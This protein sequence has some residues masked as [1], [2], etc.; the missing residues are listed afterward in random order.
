MC[1]TISLNLNDRAF[2]LRTLDLDYSF[3]REFII[4]PR[5]Y[6]TENR[7]L[8]RNISKHGFWGIGD[9]VDGFPLYA[10][11]VNEMGLTIGGL[12]F[13]TMNGYAR[14]NVSGGLAPFEIIPYVLGNFDNAREACN[15]LSHISVV[16]IQFN[17]RIKNTPLHFHIADKN[18]CFVL[19]I[20][21][22]RVE[23]KENPFGVLT[24]SPPFSFHEYNMKRY[25]NIS[26]DAPQ[27]KNN[28]DLYSNGLLA[29]GLPGDFS[30]PSRFV[31][32]AWLRA[33]ARS[34][35][36]KELF[37]AISL[38]ENLSIPTGAVNTR[39]GKM[40]HTRYY[41]L[42]DLEKMC[43]VIRKY[44]SLSPRVFEIKKESLTKDSLIS[45]II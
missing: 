21:D 22:R 45:Y 26:P 28:M 40:H 27:N 33:N 16:D 39:S 18:E 2:F 13:P 44:E 1:T 4:S 30:S 10:E 11:G 8:G 12:R 42:Y 6:K 29:T 23:I 7:L 17:E 5:G 19:E 37:S 25:L 15:L 34:E 41:S 43:V 14:S 38:I 36:G 9:I 24:N 3:G 35:K 32:A 31:R 20:I